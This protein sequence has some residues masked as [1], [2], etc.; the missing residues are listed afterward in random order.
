MS[1]LSSLGSML[2]LPND[3]QQKQYGGYMPAF[4]HNLA[5]EDPAMNQYF[6]KPHDP[7]QSQAS[8]FGHALA[9]DNPFMNRMFNQQ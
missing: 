1:W 5:A 8:R 4:G 2:M 9:A 3:E 6:N 7:N